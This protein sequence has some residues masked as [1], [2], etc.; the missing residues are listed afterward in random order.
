MLSDHLDLYT[1]DGDH[2]SQ[3]SAVDDQGEA[4]DHEPGE[5]E[6]DD[7]IPPLGGQAGQGL[8]QHLTGKM[9][10]ELSP[11]VLQT[12]TTTNSTTTT[13]SINTTTTIHYC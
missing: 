8:V 12:T 4:P 3:R 2:E 1:E 7:V 9:G 5:D 13:T 11:L 6:A 10:S